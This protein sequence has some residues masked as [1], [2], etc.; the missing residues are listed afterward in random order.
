[1]LS[2]NIQIYYVISLRALIILLN[3]PRQ[4]CF[5]PIHQP[6]YTPILRT[7]PRGYAKEV[8]LPPAL[9]TPL[10]PYK[11]EVI[12]LGDSGKEH[13]HHHYHYHKY[14]PSYDNPTP[15]GHGYS[16]YNLLHKHNYGYNYN[17]IIGKKIRFHKNKLGR[18]NN[19]FMSNRHRPIANAWLRHHPND[20]YY[21]HH[22]RKLHD[23]E[24]N[25]ELDHLATNQQIHKFKTKHGINESRQ[26]RDPYSSSTSTHHSNEDDYEDNNSFLGQMD[27]KRINANTISSDRIYNTK[28]D[29]DLQGTTPQESE[30]KALDIEQKFLANFNF[31][32]LNGLKLSMQ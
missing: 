4:L 31:V 16:H 1:M 26:L 20:Y 30:L 5:Y 10:Y 18:L 23:Y 32:P 3:I 25:D 29:D 15:Y 2:R 6:Y 11:T 24:Y 8:F 13:H 28:F 27:D 21:H 17:K 22:E 9:T 14:G 12:V 19:I 7:I